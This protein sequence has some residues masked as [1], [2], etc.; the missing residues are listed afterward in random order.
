[1]NRFDPTLWLIRLVL[2]VAIGIAGY[3]AYASLFTGGIVV[4]C[5]DGT[6]FGCGHVL[7]SRWATWFAVPVSLPAIAIYLITL[8]A[9]LLISAPQTPRQRF[10]WSLLTGLATLIGGAA[11]WFVGLQLLS[12]GN[13]CYYCLAL[14]GCGLLLAG[15]VAWRLPQVLIGKIAPAAAIGSGG[16]LGL[17]GLT[18]LIG[19]QW[20]FAPPPGEMHITKV[21]TVNFPID[22]GPRSGTDATATGLPTTDSSRKPEHPWPHRQLS[23]LAGNVTLDMYDYPVVGNREALQPIVEMFD[24]TCPQCRE[25]HALMRQVHDEFGE[26]LALVLVPVPL[27]PRCNQYATTNHEDHATACELARIALAV[28]QTQ[29]D[30]FIEFHHRLMTGTTPPSPAEAEAAAIQL[31][32]EAAFRE[33]LKN[34]ILEQQLQENCRIYGMARASTGES[35]IPK[36]IHSDTAS[37]GLPAGVEE[38]RAFLKKALGE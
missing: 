24:Y 25:L 19:G 18:A 11:I 8:G 4:G 13:L 28:W 21:S 12:L 16:F 37:S 27:N 31:L 17:L 38:L 20:F 1:M 32:G 36:M 14:H 35:T 22:I 23:L 10:G 29:P 6:P 7:T 33:A 15:F 26:D 3:L 34:P 9:T 30:A 5:G 2:I